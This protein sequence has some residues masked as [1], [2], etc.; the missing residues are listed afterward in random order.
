MFLD[1][2]NIIEESLDL[3][4]LSEDKNEPNDKQ[5]WSSKYF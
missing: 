4:E 3:V 2:E 5:K 1:W